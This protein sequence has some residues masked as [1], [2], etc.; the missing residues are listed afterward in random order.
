VVH[1]IPQ[2]VTSYTEVRLH[3]WMELFSKIYSWE[4]CC[5]KR[6]YSRCICNQ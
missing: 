4:T 3:I 5:Y 2:I 1:L 6:Q